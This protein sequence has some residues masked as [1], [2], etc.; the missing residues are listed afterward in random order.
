MV[1]LSFFDQLPEFLIFRFIGCQ[2]FSK[3]AI[4]GFLH[5]FEKG[6][7]E[8]A[9]SIR[10]LFNPIHVLYPHQEQKRFEF[11]GIIDSHV[12]ELF[13]YLDEFL[14]FLLPFVVLFLKTVPELRFILALF[15]LITP[16]LF[17]SPHILSFHLWFHTTFLS[18]HNLQYP[19][20]SPPAKTLTD[21]QKC[22]IL[23]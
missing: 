17:L 12:I 6:W 22:S 1:F 4:C 10:K 5:G 21:S 9:H 7:I 16:Y 2:P 20:V 11:V 18:K 19:L 3:G 13:R 14:V 8:I 23:L 15:Y